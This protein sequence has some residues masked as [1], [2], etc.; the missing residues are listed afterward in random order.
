MLNAFALL[1]VL[2][3]LPVSAEL[4]TDPE[5]GLRTGTITVNGET[6]TIEPNARLWNANLAGADL[7]NANLSGA[8]LDTNLAGANLRD[9]NLSGASFYRANLTD[10]D[11]TG[12]DLTGVVSLFIQG[13][14]SALPTDWILAAG[15]LLGPG[16]RL[17]WT[18]AES[19]PPQLTNVD[20][21]GTNLTGIDLTGANLTGTNLTDANLTDV[22]LVRANLDGVNFTGASLDGVKRG[23]LD[24]SNSAAIA[25]NTAKGVEQANQIAALQAQAPA[26][27]T[28][29][30]RGA[31][32]AQ[33]I[34]ALQATVTAMNAQLQQLAAQIPQLQAAITEKD[35]QIAQLSERPTLEEVQDARL[36]SIV[37]AKG[38][39]SNEV[40]LCFDLQKTD[41]LKTW[42][43]FAGGTWTAVANGGVKLTLPL[44][45]AK[46]LLRVTLKG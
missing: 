14:P 25:A 41:D 30:A 16:A 11:L 26:I 39:E 21:T 42:V 13:T 20:L 5:T 27:V 23:T 32:Q 12:A 45:E 44:N 34:A 4:V 3:V 6:Y 9:A 19:L 22:N 33:E 31:A 43:P 46:K 17:P 37:L 24:L 18:E 15:Y 36:G 29:T 28:N 1:F 35:E 2:T 8:S 10:A 38:W 40:T 7:R